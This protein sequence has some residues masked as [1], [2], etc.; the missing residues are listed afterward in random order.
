MTAAGPLPPPSER[1]LSDPP[2]LPAFRTDRPPKQYTPEEREARRLAR[3]QRE[4]ATAQ[5]RMQVAEMKRMG[6]TAAVIAATL[7]ITPSIVAADWKKALADVPRG[8]LE[9]YRA[10]AR[11]STNWMISKAAQLASWCLEFVDEAGVPV[12]GAPVKGMHPRDPNVG[13]K[14]L[15]QMRGG[16]TRQS[17]LL[18]LDMPQIV[19][20]EGGMNAAKTEAFEADLMTR[21]SELDTAQKAL[22]DLIEGEKGEIVD[23]EV[24]YGD[25]VSQLL[26][27]AS[28]ADQT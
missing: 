26:D 25:E 9:D 13:L 27:A 5:R 12:R 8:T 3:S 7:G 4:D 1:F 17:A 19:R 18:G 2:P 21:L 15:A 24:I 23:A 11:E 22:S 10:E 28:K 20:L 16:L 6:L 14:A